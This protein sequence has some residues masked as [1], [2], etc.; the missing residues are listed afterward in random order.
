[1]IQ[2][3][4]IV[5][6]AGLCIYSYDFSIL[7]DS[8]TQ[9]VSGFTTAINTF[10]QTLIDKEQNIESLQMSAL[11]IRISSFLHDNLPN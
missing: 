1:M 8:Y 9:L 2:R 4:M 7:S 11:N 10:S 3:V 6:Q 5:S